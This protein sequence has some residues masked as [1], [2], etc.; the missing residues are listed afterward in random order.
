MRI[1][2]FPATI[3]LLALTAAARA[4]VRYVDARLAGGAND[5]TSWAS[6]YRG[7]GGLQ[8]ALAA[9]QPDDEIWVAQGTYLPSLTGDRAASFVLQSRVALFGGFAGGETQLAQR[10]PSMHVAVLDG[11]LA[12]DDGLG[13]LG[14]N[15][16]H[17]VSAGTAGLRGILDGF[18]VRGGNAADGGGFLSVV[19]NPTIRNCI[20]RDN[21]ASGSGGGAFV[22]G[23]GGA[24]FLNCRFEHNTALRGGGA[25]VRGG[26]GVVFEQCVFLANTATGNQAGGALFVSSTPTALRNCTVTGNM[27]T[28]GSIAGVNGGGFTTIV[29]SIVAG[30]LGSTINQ[31]AYM[32]SASWSC[33]RWGPSGPG[34]ISADPLFLDA[35]AGDVR[36]SPVSPCIDAGSN[37]EVP[38]A[39]ASDLAGALR[40]VEQ[41]G[42]PDTGAGTA[43]LVDLGA[44]EVQPSFQIPFC[45]GDGS[46][47]ACPCGNFGFATRGCDNSSAGTPGALLTGIGTTVPDLV[48]LH[49]TGLV[50][51]PAGILL[52]SQTNGAGT[53]FGDGI[54]CVSGSL[55]RL[56]T[57]PVSASVQVLPDPAAG[58]P[59]ISVRSAALGDPIPPG[60]IRYYQLYYRDLAAGF[61]AAPTGATW[62]LTNGLILHW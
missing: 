45:A 61:C 17:V 43:P 55:T 22:D 36:L 62:N 40:F 21:R 7:A 13:G 28:G 34:V 8:A 39:L 51:G 53:L 46:V 19:G 6:A 56:Y 3:T 33:I 41:A 18:T 20:L 54:L 12:G 29:N 11:D 37:A 30:N 2:L 57:H 31:D 58:D 10:N 32:V 16:L 60:Q 47:L 25:E 26:N 48:S 50:P 42:M 44:Y 4:D 5:G 35:A 1:E 49:A 52:Q 23:L 9:A 59:P 24:R 14:D 27:A 15:S 38:A